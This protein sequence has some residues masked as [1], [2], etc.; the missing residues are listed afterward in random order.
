MEN[1]NWKT[2]GQ[3]TGLR[4]M[5]RLFKE[6]TNGKLMASGFGSVSAYYF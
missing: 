6:G 3:Q 5:A 4:D 2:Y 1:N